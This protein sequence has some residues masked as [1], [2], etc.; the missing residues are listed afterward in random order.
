MVPTSVSDPPRIWIAPLRPAVLPGLSA[1]FVFAEI[2]ES[3]MTSAPLLT[4]AGPPLLDE[5]P[6][7]VELLI[8]AGPCVKTPAPPEPPSSK[9]V[10]R[11]PLKVHDVT[12][13]A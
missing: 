11:F 7:K 13:S 9:R 6:E 5:F 3:L 2:V 12:T 8:V 1:V 4:M 10:V